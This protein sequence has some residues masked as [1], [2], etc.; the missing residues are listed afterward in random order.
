MAADKIVPTPQAPGERL[1]GRAG[2][3]HFEFLPAFTIIAVACHQSADGADP[4]VQAVIDR[5]PDHRASTAG[6]VGLH[7]HQAIPSVEDIVLASRASS[8][9]GP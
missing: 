5:R 9:D 1:R 4:P 2:H 6:V 7:C 8:G 3:S